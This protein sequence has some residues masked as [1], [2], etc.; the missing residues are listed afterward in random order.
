MWEYT[1]ESKYGKCIS[2]SFTIKNNFLTFSLSLSL[3][4]T[5]VKCD[6][7]N[8]MRLTTVK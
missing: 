2:Y 3:N 5:V 6:T 8:I 1:K 4:K 7:L